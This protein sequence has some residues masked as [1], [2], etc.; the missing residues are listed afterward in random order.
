MSRAA[1][2]P[3]GA[4]TE[5]GT[6]LSLLR[7]LQ[8]T[9]PALPIGAYAYSH[10]FEQAVARGWIGNEAEAA[11]WIH[12]LLEY[13]LGTLDLPVLLRLQRAFELD[14]E[15][16]ARR[17]MRFTLCCREAAELRTEEQQLGQALARV[18]D[19]LGVERARRYIDDPCT[20]Y[21]GMFALGSSTF[22]VPIS[23]AAPAFLFAWVEHQVSCAAR[24][25][26][27]GQSAAQ[28]VLSS[29]LPLIPRLVARAI[30]L[31]DEA[32][33]SSAFGLGVAS[34]LHETQYC[35]LFRS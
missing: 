9:S 35:R 23:R 27:L 25:V 4:V 1:E 18:L 30:D 19:G 16:E 10:G 31:P 8:L 29:A 22:D 2:A 14:D 21:T 32:L 26:P 34:A 15:L 5:L 20:T 28:R 11:A 17:W 7:L 3:L 33:G 12:G 13:S 24:L 6:D